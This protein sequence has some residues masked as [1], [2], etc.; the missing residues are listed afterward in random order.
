METAL[1]ITSALCVA[2]IIALI[3]NIKRHSSTLSRA[4]RLEE[5][6]KIIEI[7]NARLNNELNRSRAE[8]QRIKSE[9][10]N[11]ERKREERFEL[12]ARRV[13]DRRGEDLRSENIR[14]I[15]QVL[16]PLK[17]DITRFRSQV[18]ECYASEARERFSLQ[19]RIKDL[20]EANKSIGREARELSS[21]LRG[22]SKMQGD[23]GELILE[24]ILEK[25]GLRRNEEFFVQPTTD[26]AGNVVRNEHGH[27]LRPDVVVRYPDRGVMV[28]DSK[29]SLTAF[30][31]YVNS[32]DPATK[33][34]LARRHLDSV[35]KHI[36]ELAEKN[37]QDYIGNQS[38]LD[39]VMMFIPNES[40]YATALSLDPELWQKAYD[41]RVVIASP[42]QLVG[43]LRLVAQLWRH[44]RQTANAIEIARKSGQMYDKFAGFVDD[45]L[46]IERS[47]ESTSATFSE[48]M[49]KL[50]DGKGNLIS[51][52]E[53]L[54][55]LGVK[56]AKQLPA[57]NA[58]EDSDAD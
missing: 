57:T 50:R 15:E 45:M 35:T 14:Q 19:E 51:R 37:Y 2:L 4:A 10:D 58:D 25:S 31:E 22:N 7:D 27:A 32:D 18:N 30:V 17:E 1:I 26:D 40:A 16:T 43:A 9:H 21:A 56:T 11:D 28:I 39:F 29:V 8:I 34:I 55:E 49:K 6:A 47:L 3:V 23:W 42:T 41:K 33:D 38:K 13:L 24:S 36:R 20:I 44:D 52:A 12:L 48:A 53:K 54:R 46:R 5:R